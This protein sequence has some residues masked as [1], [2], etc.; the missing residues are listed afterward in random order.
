MVRP[1]NNKTGKV[2]HIEI[3]PAL[4]EKDRVK[5]R[6]ND[7]EWWGRYKIR[8]GIE[9][10][11]SELARVNGIKHLRVRRKSRV[12]LSVSLKITACNAKRWITSSAATRDANDSPRQNGDESPGEGGIFAIFVIWVHTVSNAVYCIQIFLKMQ[13]MYLSPLT[14]MASNHAAVR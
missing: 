12:T 11:M 5:A 3:D 10:T 9:A 2:N 1:P 6:Q 8:A 4:I 7:I 13:A 14:K